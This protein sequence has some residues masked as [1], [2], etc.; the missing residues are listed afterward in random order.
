MSIDGPLW[1]LMH[2]S[3]RRGVRELTKTDIPEDP[4][5]YAW[6]RDGEAIYV[7]KADCLRTRLW[8]KHLGRGPVMTGSAFRRNVTQEL[9]LAKA[10]DIKTKAYE[11]TAGEVRAVRAFI[12]DCEVAWVTTDTKAHALRLESR[13]K[14][15]WRPRLT[16]M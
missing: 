3:P 4:G 2:A 8:S 16:R 6:Y 15:E 14:R 9:D 10:N 12:E 1:K 7:G 13:M 11:P 5:V